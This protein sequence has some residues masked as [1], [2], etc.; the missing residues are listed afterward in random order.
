[1]R[2]ATVLITALLSACETNGGYGTASRPSSTDVNYASQNLCAWYG[3]IPGTT[4]FADCFNEAAEG[5]S[6]QIARQPTTYDLA[7]ATR[8]FRGLPPRNQ[9]STMLG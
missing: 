7:E 2:R 1:M 9:P 8:C 3:Y 6:L 5:Y 4:A